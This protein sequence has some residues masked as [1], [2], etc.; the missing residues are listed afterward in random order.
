M[1]HA[2]I[3][4]GDQAGQREK[5]YAESA[6]ASTC[7]VIEQMEAFLDRQG[8]KL[9]VILSHGAGSIID[10]LK[11]RPRWDRTFLDFLATRDVPVVDMRDEHARDFASFN[12]SPQEYVQRFFIGHYSPAGNFLQALSIRRPVVDWVE[13]KPKPYAEQ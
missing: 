1:P 9:M 6:L 4:Q 7:W 12:C 5:R 2:V 8:S 3:S 10:E 13:P 11:G